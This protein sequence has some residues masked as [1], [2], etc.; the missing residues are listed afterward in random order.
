MTEGVRKTIDRMTGDRMDGCPWR[1]FARPIVS[2]VIEA[3][4][5]EEN[6]NL[7]VAAPDPSHKLVQGIAHYSAVRSRVHG[8]QQD[9]EREERERE[10]KRP[11]RSVHG[12]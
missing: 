10:R 6:G 12:R 1:A 8:L 4:Q 5:F 7:A 9:Q 11:Q 3:I 2:R